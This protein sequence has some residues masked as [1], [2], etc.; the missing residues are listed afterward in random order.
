MTSMPFLAPVPIPL[1]TVER[2]RHLTC[3]KYYRPLVD[4]PEV[5]RL[6]AHLVNIPCHGD[7]AELS[8]GR[9]AEDLL[10]CTERRIRAFAS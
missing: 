3:A 9:I 5:T 2:T 7:V 4:L 10:S 1:E 8:D 6:F